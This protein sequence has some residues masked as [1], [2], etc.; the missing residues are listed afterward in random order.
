[1]EITPTR[2]RPLL[3]PAQQQ[4][5]E[6]D[7]SPEREALARARE[8]ER[9]IAETQRE[10]EVRLSHLRD[11]YDQQIAKENERGDHAVQTEKNN[12]Y[13]TLKNLQRAQQAELAKAKREGEA[14]LA[15][16][17]NHYKTS[18]ERAE[19]RGQQQLDHTQRQTAQEYDYEK[20]AA[21]FAMAD[22]RK[23]N[24][25]LHNQAKDL[26][27]TKAQEIHET[28]QA[29]RDRLETNALETTERSRQNFARE[30]QEQS[31][32]QNQVLDDLRS[33]A[34]GK[35]KEIRQDTAAKLAAYSSRQKDPFYRMIELGATLEDEGD[36]Y[37]LTATIPEHEQ[38]HVNVSIKG[39]HIVL[40]GYRRNE[41]KLE[42]SPGRTKGTATYQSFHESFPLEVPVEAKQL[43]R[44]FD[45]DELVARVPKK[46]HAAYKQH[47]AKKPERARV[48]SPSFPENLPLA[49][50][51]ERDPDEEPRSSKKTIGSRTLG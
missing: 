11:T 19:H 29:E 1:M 22:I 17:Q 27:D 51:N 6:N 36:H 7:P 49:K 30:F 14:E 26:T 35:I 10:E 34:G 40:S 41:E 9:R 16:V 37:V 18:I 32:E 46:S 50:Q 28:S 31:E 45:G 48:E 25:Q 4:A 13:E 23:Q 3:P 24:E 20:R 44:A 8:A 43:S 47:Q 15:R 5:R 33:R 21:D 2:P 39:D 42:L 38:K 12:G